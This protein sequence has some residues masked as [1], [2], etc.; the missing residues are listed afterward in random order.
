MRFKGV[1][2]ALR[3]AFLG[4]ENLSIQ[5]IIIECRGNW[6][7]KRGPILGSR[8]R[9]QAGFVDT[10]ASVSTKLLKT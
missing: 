5:S 6:R 8:W 7:A 3:G 10:L 2:P 1:P 9:A 4:M